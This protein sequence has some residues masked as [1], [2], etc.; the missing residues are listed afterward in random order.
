MNNPSGHNFHFD[1]EDRVKAK[2]WTI[3]SKV[4]YLDNVEQKPREI[5]F[6]AVQQRESHNSR[7]NQ[8]ALVVKLDYSPRPARG[9]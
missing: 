1:I 8:L 4:N 7:G 2:G 6:I 5:D 3:R 9:E